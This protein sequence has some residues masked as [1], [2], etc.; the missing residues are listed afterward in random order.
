MRKALLVAS[1][2]LLPGLATAAGGLRCDGRLIDRGDS[3]AEVRARCGEPDYRDRWRQPEGPPTYRV[4]D[5]EVWVYNPG[6]GRLLS[7]LRFRGGRLQRVDTDGYGFAAPGPGQ[8]TPNDIV[9]GM[10][11]YRLL[12]ACGEPVQRDRVFVQ[13]PLHDPLGQRY[14]PVRRETW[15]YNFGPS[16]LVREVTLENG[17]VTRVTTGDHG[18]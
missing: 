9:T 15:L 1:L 3:A 16:R 7:I 18:Y 12:A 5:V 4:A 14:V 8:C 6:P 10:S 11:K 17:F 13:R 2:L